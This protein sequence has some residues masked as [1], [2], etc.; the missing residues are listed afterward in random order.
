[1]SAAAV[2]DVSSSS[3][4]EVDSEWERTLTDALRSPKRSEAIV[5]LFP[6]SSEGCGKVFST[7]E[8]SKEHDERFHQDDQV[9]QSLLS[10]ECEHRGCGRKFTKRSY[11]KV[12]MAS[13]SSK[14]KFVCP[15]GDCGASYKTGQAL[16]RHRRDAHGREEVAD[17]ACPSCPATFA[18]VASLSKH[19][20]RVHDNESRFPCD[21]CGR[22]FHK[23]SHLTAHL[24]RDHDG[25]LP[26]KCPHCEKRFVTPN[27]VRVH[28]E[29]RH[30]P[31]RCGEP[32]CGRTEFRTHAELRR[33]VAEEHTARRKCPRCRKTFVRKERYEAHVL[34]HPEEE[35][36]K[37]FQCSHE[38][39]DR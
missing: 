17:L 11:L 18:S 13:H 32:G 3:E 35:K 38:G 12:H 7:W 27:K 1:M 36:E 16:R 19:G 22:T 37:V 14:R 9:G 6:C 39:C 30:V 28:V 25:T 29:A 26:H 8:E 23:R 2:V 15:E 31:K 4:V 34:S 33:H 21:R 10:L 5:R 20:R 24:A